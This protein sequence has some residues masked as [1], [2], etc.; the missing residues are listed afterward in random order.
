MI[1]TTVTAIVVGVG[2]VLKLSVGIDR[3]PDKK[4]QEVRLLTIPI[5]NRNWDGPV[6]RRARRDA[7]RAKRAAESKAD[8]QTYLDDQFPATKTQPN[9]PRA[10][11]DD[12][13]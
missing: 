2:T 13:A 9:T 12:K 1:L 10:K 8:A 11:R 6:R 3:T 7:R 4:Y 5:W